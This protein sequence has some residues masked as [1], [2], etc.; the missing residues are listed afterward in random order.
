MTGPS[1]TSEYLQFRAR[2]VH[3]EAIAGVRFQRAL[4]LPPDTPAYNSVRS[5]A[6]HVPRL[7]RDCPSA[8][9]FEW[10]LRGG[11]YLICLNSSESVTLEFATP[12]SYPFAVKVSIGGIDALSGEP[13]HGALNRLPQDYIPLPCQNWLDA[14]QG[15]TGEMHDFVAPSPGVP[16]SD[17][18]PPP[19]DD[20]SDCIAV[21]FIPMTADA[22]RRHCANLDANA[23]RQV[24]GMPDFAE[25]FLDTHMLRG[26]MMYE[27]KKGDTWDAGMVY[28]DPFEYDDWDT[29]NGET[30]EVTMVRPSV[31]TVLTDTPPEGPVFERRIYEEAGVPWFSAY[32]EDT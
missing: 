13:S 7:I 4:R 2:N 20:E 24:Y 26:R 16:D 21:K 29:E 22:F 28:P 14:W 23:G 32:G 1:L 9:S 18:V 25:R 5:D 11:Q 30:I 6:F 19:A 12:H 10:L 8:S 3:P 27:L 17:G 31:W 15:G